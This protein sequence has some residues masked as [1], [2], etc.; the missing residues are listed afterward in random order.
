MKELIKQNEIKCEEIRK[1]IEQC[2]NEILKFVS[3]LRSH[4]NILSL[5][6]ICSIKE[7]VKIE[8]TDPILRKES[9]YKRVTKSKSYGYRA[10]I[11]SVNTTEYEAIWA[12]DLT[13]KIID[14][15]TFYDFD[16]KWIENVL[17]F[18]YDQREYTD[19]HE[20][21]CNRYFSI[22][23]AGMEYHEDGICE[24]HHQRIAFNNENSELTSILNAKVATRTIELINKVI[25][26]YILL[27]KVKK[28]L[29][30]ETA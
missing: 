26:E 4:T 27:E 6:D 15:H 12:F 30:N 5:H 18:V 10:G 28:E 9:L 14:Y 13:G 3:V 25:K 1:N 2:E 22:Y 16:K 7:C 29:S 20:A 23:V 24:Q 11:T 21:D 8:E 17:Y 19:D